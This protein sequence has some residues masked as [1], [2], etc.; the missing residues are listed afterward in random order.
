MTVDALERAFK[1]TPGGSQT[2]S[3]RHGVIG[4]KTYSEVATKASGAFVFFEDG[5]L[6]IDLAGANGT[7]P[8]GFNNP[9]VTSEALKYFWNGGSLSLPTKLE[10]EVSERFLSVMPF[11]GMCRWVRTGSEAVSGAV[12]IAQEV[13]GRASVGVFLDSYHGWHP[14]TKS[15]A[16]TIPSLLMEIGDDVDKWDAGIDWSDLSAVLVESPRWSLVGENYIRILKCLRRACERHETL[17][18]YDDVVYGF[19]FSTCGLQESSSVRPDLACFSKALGNGVP[20]GC[21]VGDSGI[22]KKAQYR[23]SS[24]FGGETS[25]LAAANAVL[26]IHGVRDV[27]GDLFD[28][29]R[30]LQRKLVTALKGTPITLYGTPQHFRFE[31]ELDGELDRFLSECM[32][33]DSERFSRLL[34][35]R[36]ANNVN[37]CMDD[38]IVDEIER[39]VTHVVDD[40]YIHNKAEG[41]SPLSPV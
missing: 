17:L 34:I 19:R 26:K 28:I 22:M 35:H 5:K 15:L 10:C 16:K 40:L 25:G 2:N 36:D 14:W 18:I 11:G 13:T 38:S 24:T 3:R 33:V 8:L 23:V 4:P 30:R 9:E 39:T 31:S 27:C 7:C 6:A 37:L 29:G 12:A 32:Q 1:V 21:I 41:D 20:V